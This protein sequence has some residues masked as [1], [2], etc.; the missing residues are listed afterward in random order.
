MHE[1]CVTSLLFV[2]DSFSGGSPDW[3]R[4]VAN[5][6]YPFLI[7]LRDQGV[8]G[9]LL[10][11]EEIIPTGQEAWAGIRVVAREII[12]KYT[13]YTTIATTLPPYTPTPDPSKS[14]QMMTSTK[15]VHANAQSG[16]VRGEGGSRNISAVSGISGALSTNFQPITVRAAFSSLLSFSVLLLLT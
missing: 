10:P 15:T 12:H 2:V 6:K 14:T 5:I 16:E 1:H 7:E 9:F 13:S 3:A 8:Y 11:P 4:G